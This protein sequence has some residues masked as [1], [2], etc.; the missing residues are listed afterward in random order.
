MDKPASVCFSFGPCSLTMM[1]LLRSHGGQGWVG[2]LQVE[3]GVPEQRGPSP[4][5]HSRVVMEPR[6]PGPQASAFPPCFLP[7][8]PLSSLASCLPPACSQ[9]DFPGC[10]RGADLSL[11]HIC[12]SGASMSGCECMSVCVCVSTHAHWGSS[13]N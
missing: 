4:P 7:P 11:P 12:S 9:C 2:A 6:E 5:L 10:F 3:G 8:P 1:S 13:P